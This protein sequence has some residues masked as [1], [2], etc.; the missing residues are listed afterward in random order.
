M[1][2]NFTE[3]NMQTPIYSVLP[4]EAVETNPTSEAKPS[5]DDI[6]S[7]LIPQNGHVETKPIEDDKTNLNPKIEK[8]QKF[9]TFIEPEKVSAFLEKEPYWIDALWEA[10]HKI[11]EYY[12]LASV[13]LELSPSST[14]LWATID[15]KCEAEQAVATKRR[16]DSDWWIKFSRY[17]GGK[18]SITLDREK[19]RIPG[20]A[21]DVLESLIGTYDGPTDWSIEHDHYLYGTPKHSSEQPTETNEQPNER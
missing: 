11:L 10:R 8:L 7:S 19:T 12:P 9:Y 14:P 5:S 15:P 1:L 17:L 20:D 3:P 16:F 18:L 13:T 21:W 2:N 4:S 6:E